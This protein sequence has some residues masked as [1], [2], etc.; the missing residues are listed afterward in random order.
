MPIIFEAARSPAQEIVTLALQFDDPA[1]Q[2]QA[3]STLRAER[4]WSPLTLIGNGMFHLAFGAIIAGAA[5]TRGYEKRE[6]VRS[7]GGGGFFGS[8]GGLYVESHETEFEAT[9]PKPAA[10][11]KPRA[12]KE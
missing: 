12:P 4:A 9:K 5:I 2:I 10:R 3:L 7:I 8:P 6:R 11:R 1:A